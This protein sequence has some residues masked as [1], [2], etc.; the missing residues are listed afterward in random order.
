M[1]TMANV[2]NAKLIADGVSAKLG[3]N[4]KLFPITAVQ[5]L[6]GTPGAT[7]TVPQ[8][9]YIGDATEFVDGEVMNIVPLSQVSVDVPVVQLG[10][11]TE[12]TDMVLHNAYG[13]PMEVAETQLTKS[14]SNGLESKMFAVLKGI[15][16]GMVHPATATKLDVAVI[17]DALVKFG[18]D[19]DGEKYLV[20]SPAEFANLRKDANF[21]VKQ[22]DK[23]DS[24]GEIYGCA[25][26]VSNGVGAKEAFIIKPGA[27]G[28]YLKKDV[29]VE[30]DRNI[31]KK[32]TVLAA[33]VQA[34]VHLRDASGAIKI[35]LA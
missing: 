9:Q 24:V 16:G 30:I 10:I 19:V 1:T 21:V 26:V 11:S 4:I 28:A 13:D 18:E 6:E 34:A 27:L 7:I 12:L 15:T 23:V 29:G 2:L 14:V 3:N 8:F 33:D 32:S 5:N 22:N 25:V 31:V 17:G 20:V 35:T